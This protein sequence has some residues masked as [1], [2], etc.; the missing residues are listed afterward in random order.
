[1]RFLPFCA[2]LLIAATL[3]P[4]GSSPVSSAGVFN[5]LQGTWSGGGRVRLGN[6]KSEKLKCRAYYRKKGKSRLGLAIRC[7]SPS[8]KIHMRGSLRKRGSSVS[9]SWEERTFNATGKLNGSATGSSIRLA[10]SGAISGR[11]SIS[12]RG[13]RKTVSLSLGGGGFDGVSLSF[14]R[15][16]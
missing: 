3:M 5:A 12:L 13:K 16:R 7:A 9:G 15:R 10:I 11:L 8:N 1:M 14:R 4:A 2:A 6:G